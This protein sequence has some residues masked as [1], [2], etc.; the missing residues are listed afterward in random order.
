MKKFIPLFTCLFVLSL[1]A[2]SYYYNGSEKVA[3]NESESSFISFDDS[4]KVNTIDRDF[5]KIKRFSA[6]EF[7]LLNQKKKSFSKQKFQD[8]N[9][10]QT[11]PAL[12]INNNEK[13][14]LYPTKT[15]RVKLKTNNKH[16]KNAARAL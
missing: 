11:T 10:N 1:N 7:T 6:K 4:T 16:L 12:L 14:Q 13:L 8:N 5:E 2:Q 15:V 9:L 3:I